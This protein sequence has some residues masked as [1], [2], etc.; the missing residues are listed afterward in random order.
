MPRAVLVTG[1]SGGIGAATV[2]SLGR[3]GCRVAVGYRSDRAT[4]DA[5]AGAIRDDGGTAVA[6]GGDV[7]EEA[8][9]ARMFAEATDVLGP[10]DGCVVN[11]GVQADAPT[12]DMTLDQWR[13]VTS[14][15]L[16]GAFLTAR[17][18]LN[19]LPDDGEGPRG[20]LV[21]VTSVHA[22]IPW[23]G[24]AN[25]AAAKAGA[26]MLMR[27]LAQEVAPAGI[28]VNA[29]APG[30]IATDINRDAWEDDEGRDALL[31]LIPYGRLGTGEDVARA[32]AWLLSDAA[33]YVTG[34][35]LIVDGGMSLYPGFVGNG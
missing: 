12:I 34:T 17:T 8:D 24:H 22:H 35:T 1:G 32:V 30:A 16:D 19:G 3:H 31:R 4:A 25:Y 23:A 7:S 9:V 11:A 13:R 29:V 33:D 14:T 28:R 20:V 15:D 10:L 6:V 18:F 26:G 2:R 5:V 21:F 27:T